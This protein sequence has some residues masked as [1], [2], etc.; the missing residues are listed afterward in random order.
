M[1]VENDDSRRKQKRLDDDPNRIQWIAIACSAI[2]M[3][4]LFAAV[5]AFDRFSR[6]RVL[7]ATLCLFLGCS[8]NAFPIGIV[9]ERLAQ[10]CFCRTTISVLRMTVVF[11]LIADITLVGWML[12]LLEIAP[13]Q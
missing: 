12:F 6:K 5:I 13:I 2:G 11:V 10:W 3:I 1:D 9:S 8:L 4:V 7:A